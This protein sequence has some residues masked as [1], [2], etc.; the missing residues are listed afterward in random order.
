MKEFTTNK[1]A[2][3]I[4]GTSFAAPLLK[5]LGLRSHALN[6][7]GD[8]GNL[9]SLASKFAL[10]VWGDSSKLGS[11]GNHTK[12]V[13]LEKLSKFHKLTLYIDEITEDSIDIYGMCNESGRH[14]L[15]RVGQILE[16]VSWKTVMFS[17][18]ELMS[19]AFPY[20]G[21]FIAAPT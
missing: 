7:F 5:V 2:E 8:S 11:A 21:W 13:L 16:A 4:M 17:T 14:R 10:S 15:N 3:F 6:F 1:D 19:T 12:N 18:S 20:S 9:K